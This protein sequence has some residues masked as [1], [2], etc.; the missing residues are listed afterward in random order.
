[1]QS[2]PNSITRL[3]TPL[4]N[5]V[6]KAQLLFNTEVLVQGV[7]PIPTYDDS[8]VSD[9]HTVNRMFVDICRSLRCKFFN[10][11]EKF[12]TRDRFVDVKCY[13]YNERKRCVDL[14]P[15][16]NGMSILARAYISCIRGR[17]APRV[18]L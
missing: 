17:F 1:M 12:L 13:C 11:L 8:I 5:M 10:V 9:V 15:N 6:R 16:R 2:K 4:K 7:V 14:H 3:Y 18:F